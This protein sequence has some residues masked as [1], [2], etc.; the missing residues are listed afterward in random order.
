MTAEE[1]RKAAPKCTSFA[2]ELRKVFWD[3]RIE[4]LDEGGL[5][6]GKPDENVYASCLYRG[7][8]KPMGSEE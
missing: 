4:R 6:R 7:D 2:A 5:K 1:V 3:V 8:G